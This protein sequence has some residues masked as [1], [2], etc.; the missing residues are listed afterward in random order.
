MQL[1]P[2]RK[3]KVLSAFNT[4]RLCLYNPSEWSMLIGNTGVSKPQQRLLY[5][6]LQALFIYSRVCA[7]AAA[8]F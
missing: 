7:A 3:E 1:F 5:L 8:A 6:L 4:P 2:G